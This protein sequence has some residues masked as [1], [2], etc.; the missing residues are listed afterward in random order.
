MVAIA[1]VAL[2][3]GIWSLHF[4]AMLGLQLPILFSYDGLATLISVL[5]AILMVGLA[6]S[7]LHFHDRGPLTLTL[8]AALVLSV[9]AIWIAYGK[10]TRGSI[11]LGTLVFG[12]SV[13][14]VHF[15]AMAGT[16]FIGLDGGDTAG[17]ALSHFVRECLSFM[18]LPLVPAWSG[19]T[20][21]AAAQD[22][23]EGVHR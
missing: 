6:L 4:V 3:G 9:A 19:G 11:L 18:A 1:A 7:I 14:A 15:I 17:P 22:R 23:G 8:A 10:R 13:F 21:P 12:L 2:G 20:V 16:G 5:I